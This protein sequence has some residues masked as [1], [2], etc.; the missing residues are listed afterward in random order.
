MKLYSFIIFGGFSLITG[1]NLTLDFQFPVV[2]DLLSIVAICCLP[3]LIIMISVK[4]I[5]GKY[6]NYN[7]KLFHVFHFE[8]GFY[9][10]LRI[11]KWK[12]KVPELG[13]IGGFRKNHIEKPKD[14]NYLQRYL[15]ENCQ[16]EVIHGTSAVWGFIALVF[17]PSK[18]LLIA[19]LP[20]SILNAL[21]HILPVLIQRYMRP[22][23]IKIL[24]RV[25]TEY[26]NQLC[27][28]EEA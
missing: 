7:S 22:R 19:A 28:N 10:K 18:Y 2:Y 6:F 1:L 16:A 27:L 3:S 14:E 23:L 11:K 15:H 24:N 8:R 12:D 20:I 9:E 17:I 21:L 4:L 5:P 13:N 25:S 26:D